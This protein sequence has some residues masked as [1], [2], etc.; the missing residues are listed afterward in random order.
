MLRS[1]GRLAYLPSLVFELPMLVVLVR[2]EWFI[3][4]NSDALAKFVALSRSDLPALI[5]QIFPDGML[6]AW[7]VV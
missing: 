3:P 2:I 1:F 4:L 6:A 7:Q 5:W